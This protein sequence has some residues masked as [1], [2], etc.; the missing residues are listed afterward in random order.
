[1]QVAG[2]DAPRIQFKVFFSRSAGAKSQTVKQN[3]FVF[4]SNEYI[5]PIYCGEADKIQLA[6][7]SE[8]VFSAQFGNFKNK[9]KMI[10][11]IKRADAQGRKAPDTG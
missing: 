6:V 11:S 10:W 2:H 7:V 4:V 8:F 9:G 5:N 1:M 3:F